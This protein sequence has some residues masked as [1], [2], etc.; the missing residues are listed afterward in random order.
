MKIFIHDSGEKTV[1]IHGSIITVETDFNLVDFDRNE[2]C[3]ELTKVFTDIFDLV[4]GVNVWFEDECPDC[5]KKYKNKK[6]ICNC[7]T[8]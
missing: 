1:G 4:G 8:S 5:F 2:I 6:H 7:M 3:K